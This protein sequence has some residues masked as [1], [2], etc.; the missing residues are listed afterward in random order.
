[1]ARLG[2]EPRTPRF[3]ATRKRGI[4]P[5][6]MS[7]N[8]AG[9]RLEAG[10]VDICGLVWFRAGQGR[11]GSATS[12]SAPHVERVLAPRA[13]AVD[14]EVVIEAGSAGDA[15]ALHHREA[16]AVHDRE[17]LI[18]EGFADPPRGVEVAQ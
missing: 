17:V 10:C 13:E 3:S 16:G 6:R 4:G 9:R 2:I 14:R 15:K 7:C 18:G 12:C 5:G 11:G 1:M 8:S